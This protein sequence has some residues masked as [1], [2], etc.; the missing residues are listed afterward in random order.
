VMTAG[1]VGKLF[2]PG[3]TSELQDCFHQAI[4]LDRVKEREGVLSHFYSNLSFKA[5]ARKIYEVVRG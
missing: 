5:I 3:N 1:S 4:V 2:S